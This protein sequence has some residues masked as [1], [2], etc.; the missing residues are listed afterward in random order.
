M[1]GVW[2]RP[3][4]CDLTGCHIANGDVPRGKGPCVSDVRVPK[5][6][7][8]PSEVRGSEGQRVDLQTWHLQPSGQQGHWDTTCTS[9]LPFFLLFPIFFPF[10]LI[11][12]LDIELGGDV[13]PVDICFSFCYIQQFKGEQTREERE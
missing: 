9:L 2:G 12:V 13:T 1:L 10:L 11:F 4:Y 8:G 5:A 6:S 7:S 3:A